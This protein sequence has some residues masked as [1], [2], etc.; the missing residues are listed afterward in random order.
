MDFDQTIDS[1]D[2]NEYDDGFDEEIAEYLERLS[3]TSQRI[4]G[5]FTTLEVG[6]W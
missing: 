2:N 4:W 5:L 6:K 3:H 1:N